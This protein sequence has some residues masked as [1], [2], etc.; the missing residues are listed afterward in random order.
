MT[1]AGPLSVH[2]RVTRSKT[3]RRSVTHSG[4]STG[5]NV[6]A[7]MAAKPGPGSAASPGCAGAMERVL[8]M[9]LVRIPAE[10][11]AQLGPRAQL[12]RELEALGS[13]TAAG[14]LQVLSL[15]PGSRGGSSCRL[16]GPFRQ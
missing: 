7:K 11:T 6:R 13:L 9:L 3:P 1:G 2:V 12:H 15:A 10:E 8:P 14:S 16:Q 5:R 4:A